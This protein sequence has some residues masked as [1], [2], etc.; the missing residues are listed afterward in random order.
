MKCEMSEV[1]TG[2]VD[3]IVQKVKELQKE[4]QY[5]YCKSDSQLTYDGVRKQL[6]R[7]VDAYYYDYN[8]QQ[9]KQ[10]S[11]VGIIYY[12]EYSTNIVRGTSSLS[13]DMNIPQI[14]FKLTSKIVKI[15]GS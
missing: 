12:L 7:I 9:V 2:T 8:S 3:Q 13:D 6:Q 14:D 15:V 1:W 11:V 4:L 10:K 5:P